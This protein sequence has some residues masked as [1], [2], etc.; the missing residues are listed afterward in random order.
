M[1]KYKLTKK[2][3]KLYE[4]ASYY[5]DKANEY[6]FKFRDS[7]RDRFPKSTIIDTFEEYDLWT[8]NPSGDCSFDESAVE[9]F[10]SDVKEELEY[11]RSIRINE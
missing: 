6:L 2:E 4:K 9:S 10:W 11:E 1:R 7:L 5:Q 8:L 3:E